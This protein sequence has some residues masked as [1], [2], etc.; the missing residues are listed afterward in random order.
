M[1]STDQGRHFCFTAAITLLSNEY[2]GVFDN[3]SHYPQMMEWAKHMFDSSHLSDA[4]TKSL[5]HIVNVFEDLVESS[6]STPTTKGSKLPTRDNTGPGH[7]FTEAG[8]YATGIKRSASTSIR[9]APY[10]SRASMAP[11]VAGGHPGQGHQSPWPQQPLLSQAHYG[12]APQNQ[13]VLA[14]LFQAPTGDRPQATYVA[15]TQYPA[16]EGLG[17]QVSAGAPHPDVYSSQPHYP[18]N[19]YWRQ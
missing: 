14:P 9:N 5:V 10:D 11:P 19:P 15:Y 1:K 13:N 8:K 3:S 2:F 6:S 16:L 4:H 18:P 17:P 12:T 7:D